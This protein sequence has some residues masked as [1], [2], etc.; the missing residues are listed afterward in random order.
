MLLG[1]GAS[2]LFEREPPVR[3]RALL[4]W[5]LGI[6]AAFIVLRFIDGYGEPNHWQAQARCAATLIDFLN[7]TKYPPSLLF[8]TMTLGPAAVLCAFADRMHGFFKDMF[9]MFGRVPFAFYVAH[10]YLLHALSLLLGVVQGIPVADLLTFPPFYPKN[11]G[12]SLPL[13]YAVWA[14]V[15]VI[16]YPF[17]RWVAAVK[18]RN[19]AWWLSYV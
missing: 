18:A 11:Y 15:I 9:V 17:C 19:R 6:T 16:L 8:L 13:V 3:N 12:V 14:L 2:V 10:F 7:N 5:G 4:W 1:F